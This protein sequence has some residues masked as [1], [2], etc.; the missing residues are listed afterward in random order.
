MIKIKLVVQVME[1]LDIKLV[2]KSNNAWR[3][4][5]GDKSPSDPL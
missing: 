1:I 4:I 3:Q 2:L 5:S